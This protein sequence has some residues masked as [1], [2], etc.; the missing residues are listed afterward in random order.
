MPEKEFKA[1]WASPPKAKKW[2]FYWQGKSLCGKSNY[3]GRLY[4]FGAWEPQAC[5]KCRAIHEG[6]AKE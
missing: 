5:A 2:H 6:T 3:A 1:G 4:Q